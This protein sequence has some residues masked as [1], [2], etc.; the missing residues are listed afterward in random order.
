M[1]AVQPM[2][3]NPQAFMDQLINFDKDNIPESV[4]KKIQPLVD[5]EN[6]T[7][8]LIAKASKACTAICTWTL[9]MH[10]Y[11]F[12]ARDVEPKRQALAS[13]QAELD[14]V[15]AMLAK[16]QGELDDVNAKLAKL[17][18]DFNEAIT[19]KANL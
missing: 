17:E 11:Y 16:A 1:G 5:D 9:A 15:N 10:T 19:T 2:L 8:E 7:P 13:A 18:A 4:I 3:G 12:I 14:E 6:F